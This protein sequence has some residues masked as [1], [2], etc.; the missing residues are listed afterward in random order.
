MKFVD[1]LQ[2]FVFGFGFTASILGILLVFFLIGSTLCGC[3]PIDI[4]DP[5]PV[6]YRMTIE[7]ST[8]EFATGDIGLE[9]LIPTLQAENVNINKVIMVKQAIFAIERENIADTTPYFLYVGDILADTIA[10]GTSPDAPTTTN[11]GYYG[12]NKACKDPYWRVHSEHPIR[13]HV[14]M[15]IYAFK[16]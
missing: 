2:V 16:D 14:D 13:V 7:I 1:K 15:L 6:W 3:E 4:T 8:D 5:T 9:S 11:K 12:L 10:V